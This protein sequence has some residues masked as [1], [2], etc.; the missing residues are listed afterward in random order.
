MYIIYTCILFSKASAQDT[1]DIFAHRKSTQIWVL[2]T[3]FIHLHTCIFA[4]HLK[5]PQTVLLSFF[6]L[7]AF[8]YVCLLF[9]FVYLPN[10]QV[11]LKTY[12]SLRVCACWVDELVKTNLKTNV[13]T[14][15]KDKQCACWVDE[16]VKTKHKTNNLP[17]EWMNLSKQTYKQT[18]NKTYKQTMCLPSRRAWRA[19][20][21]ACRECAPPVGGVNVCV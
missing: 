18:Y 2:K 4:A 6:F 1:R 21:R 12:A 13:I 5:S 10:P 15:H 20:P 11:T 7:N 9:A 14:K 19:A 17:A 16:L 8:S 3:F